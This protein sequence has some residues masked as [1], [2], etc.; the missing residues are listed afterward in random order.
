MRLRFV[1]H[2]PLRSRTRRM[3]MREGQSAL[4][5]VRSGTSLKFALAFALLFFQRFRFLKT[6]VVLA[7]ISSR[8]M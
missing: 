5:A 1:A 6:S 3:E 8:G 2:G 7:C 4:S